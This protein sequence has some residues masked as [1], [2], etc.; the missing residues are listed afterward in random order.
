LNEPLDGIKKGFGILIG[1]QFPKT[2]KINKH[3][4]V[5]YFSVENSESCIEKPGDLRFYAPNRVVSTIMPYYLKIF[6]DD[7]KTIII[8]ELI[9]TSF[10][11]TQN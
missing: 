2:M 7:P 3:P 11:P 9:I 8:P 6:R 5:F 1:Y 4:I 10:Y